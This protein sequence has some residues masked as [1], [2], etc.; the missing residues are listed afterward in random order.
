MSLS[1]CLT[2]RGWMEKTL[3][4][5]KVANSEAMGGPGFITFVL[6]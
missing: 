1:L 2:R 5:D 6:L 3:D 4:V